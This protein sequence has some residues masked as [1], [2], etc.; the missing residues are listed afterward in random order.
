MEA[1]PLGDHEKEGKLTL[2]IPKGFPNSIE[3]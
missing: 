3:I 2:P 1:I